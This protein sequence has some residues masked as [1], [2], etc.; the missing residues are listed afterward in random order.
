MMKLGTQVGLC[1]GHILLDGDLAPLHER[2]TAPNFLPIS[3]VAKWLDGSRCH[4]YAG[5]PQPKRYCVR[6]GRS[7]PPQKGGTA[8]Q[9]SA[10]VYCGLTVKWIKMPLGMEVG[11]GPGHIVLDEVPAP[12]KKGHSP[13]FLSHVCCGQMAV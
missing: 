12:K 4:W 7:F 8:P 10:H 2:G 3:F 9:F 11:L 1:P 13:Q 6:W 5:R